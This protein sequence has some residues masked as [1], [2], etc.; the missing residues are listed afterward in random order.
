L[1]IVKWIHIPGRSEDSRNEYCVLRRIHHFDDEN[2]DSG[3]LRRQV[4]TRPII[5]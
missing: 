2:P 3:S 4:Y 1:F 5:F